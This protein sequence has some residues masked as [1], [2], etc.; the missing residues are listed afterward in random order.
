MIMNISNQYVYSLFLFFYLIILFFENLTIVS[1]SSQCSGMSKSN[2]NMCIKTIDRPILDDWGFEM[3]GSGNL[4]SPWV[5]KDNN[6]SK[7][8]FCTD[9]ICGSPDYQLYGFYYA[10]FPIT[11]GHTYD[12]M[13]LSQ[14]FDL[15]DYTVDNETKYYLDFF[16][17]SRTFIPQTTKFEF[18]VTID[19]I[20]VVLISNSIYSQSHRVDITDLIRDNNNNTIHTITFQLYYGSISG[21]SNSSSNNNNNNIGF[22]D[23]PDGILLSN[24]IIKKTPI[25][26]KSMDLDACP[27]IDITSVDATLSIANTEMNELSAITSNFAQVYV[28]SSIF[29]P[30]APRF[31]ATLCLFSFY[32]TESL[33][34]DCEFNNHKRT[35]F[36][37]V[38]SSVEIEDSQFN[39][40]EFIH[41]DVFKSNA[42][43]MV[44]STMVVDNSQIS[45]T[46]GSTVF[47][48]VNGDLSVRWS[49]FAEN[50]MVITYAFS[51]NVQ[52]ENTLFR[53]IKTQSY[54]FMFQMQNI[55]PKYIIFKDCIFEDIAAKLKFENSNLRLIN[56]TLRN[57]RNSNLFFQGYSNVEIHNSSFLNFNN[58][59]V[60]YFTS[61][62]SLNITGS[63]FR[64]NDVYSLLYFSNAQVNTVVSDTVF[65]NN[66]GLDGTIGNLDSHISDISFFN[67][68]FKNNTSFGPGGVVYTT[69]Q[70]NVVFKDCTLTNNTALQGGISYFFYIQPIFINCTIEN[71]GA[72]FGNVSASLVNRLIL[73]DGVFP[74]IV[75][76]NRTQFTGTI[77]SCDI[78]NQTYPSQPSSV[79][80][81]LQVGG[82]TIASL[83][84]INGSVNFESVEIVGQVGSSSTISFVSSYR[85]LKPLTLPYKVTIL[86]CNPGYYPIESSTLCSVCPPGS[87]GYDGN[88]CIS[89]PQNAFCEGG[90]Q[91]STRPG[92]WFDENQYPRVI[93]DC[94]QSSHCLA[95]STCLEHTFGVLCSSCN[96]TEQ[97]YSWFGGCIECTHTNKLVIA[98]VIIGMI[99][100]VLW[101]HKSDSSSGLMNIVVYFAQTIMVL[102]KDVNFSILSLLNLQL[103]SGGSSIIGSICPGPFDYYQRHYTTFLAFPAIIFILLI[104]TLIITIIRKFK[105]N[106][107]PIFPRQ[108]GSFVKL[109]MNMYSP[110]S[111]ATFTIFFCQQIGIGNSVLVTD[112]SVQCSGNQYRTALKVSYSMLVVVLG[113]PMIIFILLFKNRKHNNDASIIRTYG[114]FILKYKT[115]YYYWD[116]GD[117]IGVDYGSRHTNQI[118]PFDWSITDQCPSSVETFTVHHRGRFG[119]QQLPNEDDYSI[120]L[121]SKEIKDNIERTR[122]MD[123]DHSGSEDEQDNYEELTDEQ[124]NELNALSSNRNDPFRV[125]LGVAPAKNATPVGVWGNLS[126][127]LQSPTSSSSSSTTT[128]TQQQQ[129][130]TEEVEGEEAEDGSDDDEGEIIGTIGEN[131]ELSESLKT[132]T[133]SHAK[134]TATHL[135]IDT[136][137]IL[138]SSTRLDTLGKV[139]YTIEEVLDEVR[140]KKT[141]LYLETF[142]F[143][144]KTRQPTPESYQAVVDFSHKTGDFASLSTVDL[145]V[146]ALAHTLHAEHDGLDTLKTSPEP[147][148]PAPRPTNNNNN[149]RNNNNNNPEQKKKKKNNN[150]KKKAAAAVVQK[151]TCCSHDHGK[152]EEKKDNS[153]K[154]VV[155]TCCSPATTTPHTHQVVD[156]CCSPASTTTSTEPATTTT[157]TEPTTTAT[158]TEST[159]EITEDNNNNNNNQSQQKKGKKNNKK[160]S[161][162]VNM[163]ELPEED[164]SKFVDPRE[165][166]EK[167][168]KQR[169]AEE[170]ERRKKRKDKE[171]EGE[172][173]TPDNI[174]A[175]LEKSQFVTGEEIKH[176]KVACITSDFSMQNVMLQMGLN[177]LS[178]DGLVVKQ[179]KQFV[180]KCYSCN[181]TTLDFSKVWCGACGNQTMV[182]AMTW[183]DRFG[184]VRVGKGSG[185]Q[186]NNRGKKFSMPKAKGG[187]YHTD[188]VF[189]EEQYIHRLKV[190]G[191]YYQKKKSSTDNAIGDESFESGFSF[192]KPGAD[193]TIGFGGRNPNIARRKIGKKNK[194]ISNH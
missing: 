51:S 83:P 186:F 46:T 37:M 65:L 177:L 68:T 171:D 42:T 14:Q 139:L 155:D 146:L 90:Q 174:K 113:I 96:N 12:Y 41:I 132:L 161:L 193:I 47:N 111:T 39:E 150:K 138:H 194:S 5:T 168:K 153:S 157:T 1:S 9:D 148:K 105:P 144:I 187:K 95:N 126:S 142:P 91:V 38:K 53:N 99:L 69:G 192:A 109:L 107:Q 79:L 76:S 136:N 29:N 22:D 54:I 145:K 19:H 159:K 154:V 48:I 180:L 30:N 178:V 16:V 121:L 11:K 36:C 163:D 33:F 31:S 18:T 147:T 152:V 66:Q 10:F 131:G 135:V 78:L 165:I 34:K 172:W 8:E 25:S 166:L 21:S 17:S 3:I 127:F 4:D 88:K 26:R 176:V 64:N 92:Y 28:S 189:T 13:S 133:I 74:E 82:N 73:S 164:P 43:V 59:I 49:L 103:E 112:S 20:K 50:D 175:K 85:S 188:M 120:D 6:I 156:T 23:V 56:T 183:V 57:M 94:E 101:S 106:D 170:E 2:H 63:K 40:N 72:V 55:P 149:N 97:Y 45:A 191:K 117:C 108:F 137:A 104:F 93:Y 81:Y 143:E 173:I 87:Y 130:T 119:Y 80:V 160:N 75:T 167:M 134:Q 122:K 7:I 169:E 158:T 52:F 86:P 77:K 184:N 32:L 110:I 162:I 35:I 115:S 129:S 84:F 15:L 62:G 128:I 182:K 118:I 27:T 61:V 114:A 190:T 181:T 67:C 89:C 71:N 185:K 24:T 44:S 116:I 140:D 98:I 151:D 60:F 124:L 125:A 70:N 58:Q 141:Q 123:K 179:V 102:S 100:L